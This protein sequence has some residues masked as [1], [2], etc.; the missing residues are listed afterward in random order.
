MYYT[1]NITLAAGKTFADRT[2]VDLKLEKGV[3]TRCEVVFPIGCS[4][5]VYALISDALHQVYPKNTDEQFVGHGTTVIA[6]DEYEIKELPYQLEFYG[7]N[8]DEVY[9]HIITVRMQVIPRHEIT[10][11]SMSEVLRFSN[12]KKPG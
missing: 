1:W 8:T 12:L 11:I 5:L 3:I 9:Q 7:W 2:R 4:N 6:T 10:R